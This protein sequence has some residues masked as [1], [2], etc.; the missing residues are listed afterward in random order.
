MKVVR[1]LWRWALFMAIALA[2]LATIGV[3][4]T[5]RPPRHFRIAAGAPG[6]MYDLVAHRLADE[7]AKH[8]FTVDVLATNGSVDNVAMLMR[9]GAEVALVQS[10]IDTVT[11]TSGLSAVAEMFY[12][13]VWLF[14][15]TAAIPQLTSLADLSGHRVGIGS[16]G[17][18]TN[19]VAS[20][21]LDVLGVTSTVQTRALGTSDAIAALK[22]GD[23]DAA[24]FVMSPSAPVMSQLVAD[25]GLAIY[26]YLRADAWARHLPY[27]SVVTASRG[28]LDIAGDVPPAD[29]TL[30]ATRATLLGR[31]NLQPDLARLLAMIAASAIPHPLVGDVNAFPSLTATE[32]PVNGD[33]AQYFRSGATLLESMLP[34]DIG[35]PLSRIWVWLLP[36]LVVIYPLYH[37]TKAGYTWYATSRVSGWYPHLTWVE[38]NLDRLSVRQLDE[39]SDFLRRLEASLPSK[40]RVSSR[41]MSALYELR[42]NIG[43]VSR[44]VEERGTEL[45]A[46]EAAG[47]AP[48][49]DLA[50]RPPTDPS[51]LP[52]PDQGRRADD[53]PAPAADA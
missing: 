35:S 1:V 5:E 9:G 31:E 41:Y 13:P 49:P 27:L 45:R 28:A 8:G 15:R 14:Y 48:Q 44:R 16:A 19:A 32:Y 10:G 39:Q 6:G 37:L 53:R 11:D 18:G 38:R 33:A 42:Q 40:A 2:V 52:H 34:F 21:I 29:T 17:S 3:F 22:A 20:R 26:D 4:V 7:A 12:E 24:F 25:R 51:S 36:L 46:L 30:I 50:E 43:Y 47:A 23:L